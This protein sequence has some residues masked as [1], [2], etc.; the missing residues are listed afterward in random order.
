MAT[1]SFFPSCTGCGGGERKYSAMKS[2]VDRKDNDLLHQQRREPTPAL[3]PIIAKN[4]EAVVVHMRQENGVYK[5]PLKIN[6]TEMEFIFDTGA[7]LIS[8]SAVEATFL[9][10][11]GKISSDDVIT[12]QKFMDAEGEVSV[13]TIINLKEVTIG[14]R[15]IYNVQASI[16]DNDRA[17]LLLGQSALERF[18]T[19]TIDYKNNTISLQ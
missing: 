8:I 13:G 1:L 18:G 16:V 12:Q 7:G 17:P 3:D 14:S 2:K 11:Q 5:L 9:Y 4:D 15:T 10:K 19:V 6:G